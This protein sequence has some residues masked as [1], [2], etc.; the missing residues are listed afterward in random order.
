MTPL[1]QWIAVRP[2]EVV[3]SGFIYVPVPANTM[4]K[5]GV[6][7]SVGPGRLM[8]N[9]WV[10]PMPVVPGQR[11]VYSSRV[12]QYRVGDD[13]IDVIEDESIIGVMHDDRG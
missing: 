2:T 9:R 11:V 12:D 5:I 3:P 8:R 1:R 7:E 4:C 10:R 6:V 13:Q